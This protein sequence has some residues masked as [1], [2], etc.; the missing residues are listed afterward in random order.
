MTRT[1]KT[2]N[3]KEYNVW[4]VV[5]DYSTRTLLYKAKYEKVAHR[6]LEKY[7]AEMGAIYTKDF[8]YDIEEKKLNDVT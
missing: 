3:E 7:K 4:E 8:V 1:R 6:W 2:F 5:P